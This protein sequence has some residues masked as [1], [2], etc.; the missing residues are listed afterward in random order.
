MNLNVGVFLP[1]FGYKIK[2][3]VQVIADMLFDDPDKHSKLL[4][5]ELYPSRA[6]IAYSMEESWYDLF[7]PIRISCAHSRSM[8]LDCTD[9]GKKRHCLQ[10]LGPENIHDS[11]NGSM[12]VQ[13]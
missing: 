8:P 9:V 10:T 12:V 2:D 13:L 7:T 3:V 1:Y 4:Q 5:A 11:F 6:R